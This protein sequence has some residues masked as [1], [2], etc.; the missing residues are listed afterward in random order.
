MAT[1]LTAPMLFAGITPAGDHHCFFCGGTCDESTPAKDFVKSS[2]TGLDTVT[3]S[4]WVC[5]GCVASQGEKDPVTLPDGETREGQ[6]IRGY[7]WVVTSEGRTAC[8]KAH[9]EWIAE[10][11][12]N[13]PAVPF[14]IC[15]TD[16]G[17][18][19]LMYRAAVCWSRDQ[20]TV[21]LEGE[22][23][24]YTPAALADRI[25]LCKQIAAATGKP[26]LKET[27]TPQSQM[28][29]VEHHC[30]ETPL[31]MWLEVQ[32]EPLS[33]LAAWLCPAKEEC[34]NEYP[35]RTAAPTRKS[36]YKRAKAEARLFD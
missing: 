8:T 21:S 20:V 6:K 24:N 27:L 12:L 9:R 13:P 31:A 29:I 23:I 22:L 26:A 10:Q 15:L 4:P 3:L 16:S 1:I 33:R 14:V 11:C 17:Q 32:N 5:A 7:S 36:E 35:D 34:V 25:S 18:K 2:F 30:D 28:R 19:H